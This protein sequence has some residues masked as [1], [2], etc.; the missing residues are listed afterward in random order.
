MLLPLNTPQPKH[1]NRMEIKTSF[2]ISLRSDDK[3][4]L[5]IKD[6]SSGQMVIELA[7]NPCDFARALTGL[8]LS[9]QTGQTGDLS[10]VGKRRVTEAREATCPLNGYDREVLR[11]WLL[12]NA[13]EP[14]WCINP[15]LGSRDSVSHTKDGAVLRYSVYRYE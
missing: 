12:E 11:Q 5:R 15:N 14:G 2:S 7:I 13:Q 9:G 6:E 1:R 4:N 10:V 3:I 8:Y